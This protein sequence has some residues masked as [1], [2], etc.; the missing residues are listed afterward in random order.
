MTAEV[1]GV[2]DGIDDFELGLPRQGKLHYRCVVPEGGPAS[3]L[4]F[5]IPGMG[6]DM[7]NAYN[8]VVRRYLAAKYNLVAVTVRYHC[9]RMRPSSGAH[10]IVD[11]PSVL[12]ALGEL[13]LGGYPPPGGRTLQEVIDHIGAAGQ[14]VT[15]KATFVPPDGEY[16]NFGVMQAGDHIL[17][18][19]D[20]IDRGIAFDTG[21]IVCIGYSHGGYI[22]HLVGKLAPNMLTGVI[23]NSAY[24][25]P[26][27]RYLGQT[28]EFEQQRGSIRWQFNT[29]TKWSFTDAYSPTFFG[30]S[31]M[32]IRDLANPWHIAGAAAA[33]GRKYQSRMI[34]SAED[35]VSPPPR[36]ERHADLLRHHGYDARLDLVGPDQID[37]KVFKTMVHGMRAAIPGVFDRLYPTLR[38]LPGPLDRELGTRLDYICDDLV[39]RFEHTPTPPYFRATCLQPL[40]AGRQAIRVDGLN[41]FSPTI[42]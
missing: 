41:G 35:L 18:F 17:A 16:Q 13:T 29:L 28:P 12:A 24:T 20:I 7:D 1:V 11:L 4:V 21:N 19:Y 8:L 34:V 33:A 39:Y 14:A 6:D 3:G 9:S 38:P 40:P 30:P 42:S 37:G 36:K 31:R 22:A 2:I 25:I 5:V 10:P 23:D 26:H 27:L 32:A 15:M